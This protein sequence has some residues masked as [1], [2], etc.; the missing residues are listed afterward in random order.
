MRRATLIAGLIC[1]APFV[2]RA[3]GQCAPVKIVSW[4]YTEYSSVTVLDMQGKWSI[5]SWRDLAWISE[6]DT[7]NDRGTCVV[8]ELLAHADHLPL[9]SHPDL[10]C[11]EHDAHRMDAILAASPIVS[12][13]DPKT[14]CDP[15]DTCS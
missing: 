2:A 3:E 5:G 6:H 15:G 9:T 7:F 1:L 13:C 11:D 4:P 10:R 12:A 14:K 8:R